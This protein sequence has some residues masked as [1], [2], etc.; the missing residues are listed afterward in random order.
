MT[1]KAWSS[2]L[3]ILCFSFAAWAQKGN[4]YLEK[5]L[6]QGWGTGTAHT[7]SGDDNLFGS[8]IQPVDDKWWK[9]FGD[10][11]L[12]SLIATA[13]AGNFSVLS[14][15]DRMDMAKANWRIERGS[16]FPSV[17]LNGGWARQQSS[18][19]VSEAPQSITGAYSASLNASWELDIFGSIRQRVK[20][21]RENFAASKEEYTSVMISLCAQVASAYIGLRELQQELNVVIRNCNT[22]AAVLEIT[23]VRYKT[24]LVSKL[25]VSQAKSVYYST[26]A[27]VPQLEA[28]INQYITTLAILLGTY[29]QDL[30]PTLEQNGKL[31][32]YMEPVGIGIPADLLLR[33]PDIRQAERQIN[34]Q[35]A[36][37]GASK[38]DWLPQVFL[39]GS[40][41]YSSHDLKDFTKRNS[42]TFEIA[43]SLSW[44]LFNGTKLVNATRLARAQLDESIHQFNQT[45]L[46]AVQETDNAMNGYRNSIKQIVALREVCNQGEETLKLSLDLYK[47][48]LTPFQNV[49]DALRSLLAYQNQLTQAQGNTLQELISLYK[50]LGGGYGNIISGL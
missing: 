30:R 50:A 39:K 26:K 13:S 14:A 36:L 19:N 31:P 4:S 27:S 23:Q 17:S 7:I 11:M 22:Q 29:P 34:A 49:L 6:P 47:Q 1:L 35:A 20:A 10:P 9:A 21:Q 32:D 45:V 41:G 48:G 37:L 28:G 43:P 12:D 2:T 16:F 24:G 3:L 18:G 46:T 5:P 33:R 42:M 44:T 25:D 8:Q 40:V 15:I 38:S